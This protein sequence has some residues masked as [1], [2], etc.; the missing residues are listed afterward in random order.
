MSMRVCVCEYQGV[1]VSMRVSV[2]MRVCERDTFRGGSTE[3]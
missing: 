2:S 3:N 1:F